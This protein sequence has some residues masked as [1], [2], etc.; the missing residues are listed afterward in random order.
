[1]NTASR[2]KHA[3]LY[4]RRG[5]YMWVLSGPIQV[6]AYQ[7]EGENHSKCSRIYKHNNIA[8][9]V[10]HDSDIRHAIHVHIGAYVVSWF[11]ILARRAN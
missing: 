8:V 7:T 11:V 5:S 2:E 9:Y 4:M 3:A 6:M 10:V 1:M